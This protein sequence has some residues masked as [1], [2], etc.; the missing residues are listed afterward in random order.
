M[1]GRFI[2]AAALL[3][4]IVPA[5]VG[6]DSTRVLFLHP[7]GSLSAT[8]PTADELQAP[9]P[10]TFQSG[11]AESA[12]IL[13]PGAAV[14]LPRDYAVA[15]P[16][17]ADLLVDGV[18]VGSGSVDPALLDA[19]A[20]TF[21]VTLANPSVEVARGSSIALVLSGGGGVVETRGGRVGGLIGGLLDGIVG[22]SVSPASTAPATLQFT[23]AS[24]PTPAAAPA[25]TAPATTG[26]IP[27]PAAAPGPST[28]PTDALGPPTSA[29]GPTIST[30]SG[31]SPSATGG[32]AGS[33][34]SSA[35]AAPA[36]PSIVA[37][38]T[39]AVAS[40]GAMPMPTALGLL[41]LACAAIAMAG[42]ARLGVS[43]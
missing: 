5:A 7:D 27:P 1:L 4:A 35:P 40:A 11:P 15:A 30:G 28:I 14:T 25:T 36:S 21:T 29:A 19:T 26:P 41:L 16:V 39:A 37:W 20:S 34:P 43:A 17:G 24:I 2:G 32:A 22:G 10:S 12:F 23:A 33:S 38:L 3:L 42:V 9:L 13:Q 18:L 6:V 31:P 8:P